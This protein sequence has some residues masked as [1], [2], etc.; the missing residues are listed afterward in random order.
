[1]PKRNRFQL[2]LNGVKYDFS[3]EQVAMISKKTLRLKTPLVWANEQRIKGLVSK[4]LLY[5]EKW[6]TRTVSYSRTKLGEE[7]YKTL[8]AKS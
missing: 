2:S 1:V 5:R 8:L 6:T 7:I 3:A 4:R